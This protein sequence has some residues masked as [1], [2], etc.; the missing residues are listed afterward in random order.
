MT[1]EGWV[2]VSGGFLEQ[3]QSSRG[4]IE[5]WSLT[6]LVELWFAE[7]EAV[8]KARRCWCGVWSDLASR[9]YPHMGV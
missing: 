6:Q 8:I 4:R 1:T 7:V 9:D 5:G 3:K 2:E